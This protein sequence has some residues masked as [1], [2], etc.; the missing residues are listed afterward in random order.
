MMLFWLSEKSNVD[1]KSMFS[2]AEQCCTQPRMLLFLNFLYCPAK[3]GLIGL[4]DLGGGR[5]RKAD[6]KWPKGFSIL[7]GTVQEKKLF[8]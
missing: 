7:Y 4:E 3:E 6:L 2:C 8:N 1:N 5:T